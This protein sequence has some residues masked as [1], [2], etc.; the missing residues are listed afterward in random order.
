[1]RAILVAGALG[2]VVAVQAMAGE[3]ELP[4]IPDKP[5]VEL[6]KDVPAPW[7]D[8]LIQA[9]EAER[10]ADTL[11]R[12]LAY[13]DL[14]DTQ[15]PKRHAEAHCRDHQVSAMA[16]EDAQR[17]L[18]EGKVSELDA[19]IERVLALHAKAIDPSEEIHY[20]FQQFK[21]E[22]ADAFTSDWLR[23]AP[24]S[25]YALTARANY[26][27]EAAWQARGSKF[28]SKTPREDLRRMTQL[29]DLAI[30]LFRKAIAA[31]PDFLP[32]WN[33]MLST[34][35]R[36][37]RAELEAEAFNA[38]NAIDP[39][40]QDLVAIRMESLEPR[41]G[42]SYEAMLAYGEQLK[43]LLGKRPILAREIA[44][45]YADRGSWM[46]TGKELTREAG[47]VFEVAL[48]I[49]SNDDALHNAA[50]V[51]FNAKDGSADEWK[52]LAYLLQEAR[53]RD[54]GLWANVN[55]ARMLVRRDPALA[56]KYATRAVV[57]DPEDAASRYYLA[58]SN[59]NAKQFEEAEKNYLLAAK[60]KGRRQASLR[61]LT[62]MWMFDA[63][64]DPK[65]GSTKAKPYLDQLILAYPEDGRARMYK[66]QSEGA[67]TGRVSNDLVEAFEKHADLK[68]PV[69][70]KF[71]EHFDAARKNPI[72]RM[73][74]TTAK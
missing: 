51:A 46:I 3:P 1:M 63:G 58:A 30:P 31:K 62:T 7:R 74:Q 18:R 8:Y 17:L 32:A 6:F 57:N 42:G 72:M 55:I 49:G 35:F 60:D 44:D 65:T 59:Y 25:A 33:G 12:C 4:P 2:F 52:A 38:A 71:K 43:P 53:F 19:Y 21:G 16:M 36:D 67:L 68:D 70:A 24:D 34:A 5:A 27:S 61:E 64:L 47:D 56:V 45:P 54:G 10:I 29:Y 11:Q 28:V 26:F 23:V 14:P 15:W 13:P 20:F 22:T 9:R 40:C 50:N 73:P 39:G 69:Q 37:S 66:I 41:W 48:R